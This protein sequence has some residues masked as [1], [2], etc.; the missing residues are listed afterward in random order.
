MSR[1]EIL[2]GWLSISKPMSPG[3]LLTESLLSSMKID[4]SW[5]FMM[6]IMTP[7][8]DNLVVV[9]FIDLH[10]AAER[11][12][13]ADCGDQAVGLAG[14][15]LGHLAAIGKDALHRVFQYHWPVYAAVCGLTGNQ[16]SA[17]GP[18]IINFRS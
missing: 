2:H 6:W 11:Q 16:K 12:L 5:P 7:P 1:T 18:V 13:V 17:C 14:Q 8:R 10:V 9:P 4:M 15:C 3:W